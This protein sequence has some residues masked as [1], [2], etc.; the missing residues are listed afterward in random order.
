MDD[1]L[2]LLDKEPELIDIN[3]HIEQKQVH[4]EIA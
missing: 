1:V 2:E 3:R 4:Q